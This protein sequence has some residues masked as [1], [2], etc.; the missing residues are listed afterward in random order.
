MLEPPDPE[1]EALDWGLYGG[2]KV[3]CERAVEAA[4]PGRALVVRPG[5]IAGP[6]DYTDRFPYWR[7]GGGKRICF[8]P[9]GGPVCRG[10]LRGTV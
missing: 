8:G 10:L 7:R 5:M 1:P 6:H 9:G 3:G 4:M 2:L